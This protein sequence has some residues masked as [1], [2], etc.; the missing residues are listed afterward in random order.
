MSYV[1]SKGE[2]VEDVLCEGKYGRLV[3]DLDPSKKHNPNA[4][5]QSVRAGSI[6]TLLI[7]TAASEGGCFYVRNYC[8]QNQP[9]TD[10]KGYC[11]PYP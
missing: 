1:A 8:K 9:A 5:P 7:R 6:Q 10:E 11:L 2:F 4:Q 3:L